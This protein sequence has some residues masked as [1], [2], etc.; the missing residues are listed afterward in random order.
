MTRN[1]DFGSGP[2]ISELEPLTFTLQDETF[3]CYP[4]INGAIILKFAHQT[5]DNKTASMAVMTLL[6][7]SMTEEE[8]ARLDAVLTDPKKITKMETIT[9]I[10]SYLIEEYTERPTQPS[11]PSRSGSGK[12]NR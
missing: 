11:S 7:S 1:K 9:S 3:N 6:A 4:A 5:Q 8:F 2:D 10:A 12:K